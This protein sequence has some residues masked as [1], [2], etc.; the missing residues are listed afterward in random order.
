MRIA[1]HGIVRSKK[2]TH[3]SLLYYKELFDLLHFITI[4]LFQKLGSSNTWQADSLV[5]LPSVEVNMALT[6]HP[7]SN[8]DR[9]WQL[10][11]A[12]VS[13]EKITLKCNAH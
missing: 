11:R 6:N 3:F 13:G 8:Q 4:Y 5:N 7:F 12:V 1:T 10:C 2:L 9:N